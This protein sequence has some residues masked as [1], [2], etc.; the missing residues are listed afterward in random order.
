MLERIIERDP[1]PL[2]ETRA[3][4]QRLIGCCRNFSTLLCSMLRS[5]GIPARNRM[6]FASYIAVG[7]GFAADHVV[8]EFWHLVDPQMDAL[9]IKLN[10]ID[11]DVRDMP[12][13]RFLTGGE[14]WR[15]C[16]AGEADADNFG[17]D[18]ENKEIRGWW[19]VRDKLLQ[20]LAAL[21]R[22]E[23]LCWDAWDIMQKEA[24]SEEEVQL[25]DIISD[26]TL[27]GDPAFEELRRYSVYIR[28]MAMCV[29]VARHW[30]LTRSRWRSSIGAHSLHNYRVKTG[31]ELLRIPR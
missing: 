14:A 31:K 4:E 11:F 1:R 22:V 17:I 25:L 20:D 13:G 29:P 15:R 23:M 30:G 9:L 21:N 18:P 3:P 26:L 16:R 19:L 10:G 2:S 8:V 5:R 28:S 7:P 12:Q 27:N 6:G 24:I